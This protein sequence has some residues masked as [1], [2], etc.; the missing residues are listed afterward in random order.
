VAGLDVI[1]SA[2]LNE[3][4][5]LMVKWVRDSLRVDW[6]DA[7]KHSLNYLDRLHVSQTGSML[8]DKAHST[9]LY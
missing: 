8:L 7:R 3:E 4:P 1:G 6:L 9:T 2:S 5:V